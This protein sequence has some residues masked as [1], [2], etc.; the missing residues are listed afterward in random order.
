[1]NT[2]EDHVK[3]ISEDTAE[4]VV[5]AQSPEAKR[6]KQDYGPGGP[7]ILFFILGLFASLILGWIIFPTVLYSQKKQL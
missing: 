3:V 4:G 1:M 2:S 7:I 5:A 6:E